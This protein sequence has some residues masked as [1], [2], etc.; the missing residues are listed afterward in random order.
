MYHLAAA[1]GLEQ[2]KLMAVSQKICLAA[3][4]PVFRT[5]HRMYLQAHIMGPNTFYLNF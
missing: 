1:Y 2:K 5:K 4:Y 3:L